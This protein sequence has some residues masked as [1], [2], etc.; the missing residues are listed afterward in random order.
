MTDY[1]SQTETNKFIRKVLKESFPTVKFSVRTSGGSTNIGWTDG[2]NSD[3]VKGLIGVFEGSYFDGMIDYQGSRYA[4]LDSK[5]VHFLVSFIF[6]HREASETLERR[7][8]ARIIKKYRLYELPGRPADVDTYLDR[9]HDG[10]LF[11]ASPYA[12]EDRISCGSPHSLSAMFHSACNKHTF[13]PFPQKSATLDRV[14]F[15]GSDGYGAGQPDRE[16]HG[17][18]Y[19]GYPKVNGVP[20]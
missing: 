12:N 4:W 11:E 15:K 14:A 13:S 10:L 9:L 6:Y 16:G 7:V 18:G 2:P 5:E 8:A 1:I 17:D 19:G 20:I 3:Q